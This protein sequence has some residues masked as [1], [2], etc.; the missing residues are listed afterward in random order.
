MNRSIKIEADVVVPPRALPL[1]ELPETGFRPMLTTEARQLL[2]DPRR[3]E[4]RRGPSAGLASRTVFI[5]APTRP[6][7]DRARAILKQAVRSGAVLRPK[8]C[9]AC[10]G[11]GPI[12]GHH[13]DYLKPLDLDWLCQSCHA[14]RHR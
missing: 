2:E 5:F 11:R 12:H 6:R 14:A 13:H 3:V 7:A 10:G 9:Q 4:A 8:R 1:E